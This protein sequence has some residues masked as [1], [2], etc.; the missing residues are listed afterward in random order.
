MDLQALAEK[1]HKFKKELRQTNLPIS[2]QLFIVVKNLGQAVEARKNNIASLRNAETY[3]IRKG[4]DTTMYEVCIKDTYEE[5]L[6]DATI[7]LLCLCAYHKIDL[8]LASRPNTFHGNV[9][10]D[11]MQVCTSITF[12][13]SHYLSGKDK[14][15]KDSLRD[16]LNFMIDFGGFYYI[17][18]IRIINY[19]LEYQD[20]LRKELSI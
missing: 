17:D 11:L 7:G 18:I 2:D 6:A 1:I 14:A 13:N 10:I 16:A 5:K 15:F 20:R 3:F 19:K 12:C 9:A 8:L 4:F